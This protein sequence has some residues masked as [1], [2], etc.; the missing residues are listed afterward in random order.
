MLEKV[1]AQL[2]NGY[3]MKVIDLERVI[4]YKINENYDLEISGLDNKK[5]KLEAT[6]YVWQIKPSL[7]IIETIENIHTVSRIADI[8]TSLCYKYR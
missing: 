8:V 1:L 6:I 5:R 7:Q 3:S 2:G 4:Y